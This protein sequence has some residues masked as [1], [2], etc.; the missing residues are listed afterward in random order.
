MATYNISIYLNNAASTDDGVASIT[1]T[2]SQGKEIVC[3]S[4]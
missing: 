4:G 1:A 3:S 2:P